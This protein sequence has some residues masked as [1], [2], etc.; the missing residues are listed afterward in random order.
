MYPSH[1]VVFLVFGRA[2]KPQENH[3]KLARSELSDN[4]IIWRLS[5][6]NPMAAA[7]GGNDA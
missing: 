6:R 1:F 3:K 7:T 2:F 4:R 5:S